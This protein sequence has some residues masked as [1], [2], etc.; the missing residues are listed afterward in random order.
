MDSQTD[1]LVRSA[2]REALIVIGLWLAALIYSLTTCYW[3]GYNR[4]VSELKLIFG[5]PEW[6]FWGVVVPWVTCAVISWVFGMLFVHDGHLGEE[7]PED[8]DELGLGG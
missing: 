2:R 6:V 7:L 8:S 5:F 3:L 4:P 1:P